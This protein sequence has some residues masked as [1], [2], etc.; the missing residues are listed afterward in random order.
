MKYELEGRTLKM[1]VVKKEVVGNITVF[2]I[3]FCITLGNSQFFTEI[4]IN[5]F[6]I[7]I[8][9]S[10][11]LMKIL[12]EFKTNLTSYFVKRLLLFFCISIFIQHRNYKAKQFRKSNKIKFNFVHVFNCF[13]SS[14]I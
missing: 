14:I 3:F 4:G 8:G 5:N 6:F 1:I 12:Y 10:I 9:Y 13:S 2:L 7:Y 11:V